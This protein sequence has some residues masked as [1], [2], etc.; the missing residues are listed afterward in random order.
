MRRRWHIDNGWDVVAVVAWAVWVGGGMVASMAVSYAT[1]G[2]DIKGLPA[3]LVAALW[4]FG[5]LVVPVLAGAWWCI[6]WCRR[7][8]HRRWEPITD[9]LRSVR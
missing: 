8:I 5:S 2:G 1:A 7:H 9:D 4:G 3:I 6:R